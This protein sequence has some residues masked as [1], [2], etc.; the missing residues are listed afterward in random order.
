MTNR[1]I[2]EERERAQQVENEH[3]TGGI[4][5]AACFF[6]PNQCKL[7]VQ[8]HLSDAFG[9][10]TLEIQWELSWICVTVFNS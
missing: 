1:K 9:P 6:V 8:R 3:K 5:G 10:K 4:V 2:R 7:S